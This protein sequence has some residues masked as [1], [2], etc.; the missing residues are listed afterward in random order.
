MPPRLFI[1]KPLTDKPLTG[2]AE[3]TLEGDAGHYLTRVLRLGRGASIT[4]FDGSGGEWACTLMEG[5]SKPRVQLN[6]FIPEE[7]ESPLHITLI[8][9]LPKSSAMELVIQKGTELG[10]TTLIPLHS[11]Y[12]TPR[13]NPKRHENRQRRWQRIAIEAAEQCGRTKLPHLL[14]PLTF[15]ELPD[16]LPPNDLRLIF[17]EKER[18][19]H[20]LSPL[21]APSPLPTSVTLLI[22][23][24][25]GFSEEEV[26]LAQ[27]EMGFECLGLGPRIL[28]TET[29]AIAAITAMQLLY[30]DMGMGRARK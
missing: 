5:G 26:R 29:A 24:E 23:P 19:G 16:Q 11:Q 25:G 13:V 1:D 6:T 21:A 27:E 8:H 18:D 10:L 2:Q 9:G 14:P 28:R 4:L 30:G 20:S 3:L 12:A 22:G 17:W 7:R 15:K